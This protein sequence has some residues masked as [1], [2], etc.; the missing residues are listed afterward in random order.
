MKIKNTI[1]IYST[2]VK[3]FRWLN[4]PDRAMEWMTSVTK[5]EIIEKTPKMVGTT[6]REI[7]EEDGHGTEMIGIITDY[8]PNDM[9]SFHLEGKFNS[10][11]V[12]FTVKKSGET[13]RL[14]QTAEI[15][16]KSFVRVMSLIMW[17]FFRK[18]IID[19]A[20]REFLKLKELCE[21]ENQ[22]G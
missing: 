15:H 12:K 20:Y 13:T 14:T 19:Q 9:I 6:F 10:V 4:D 2:P 1:E 8:E 22:Q 17:P 3:V 5:T 16:F 21:K 11:D 18:K 7:I